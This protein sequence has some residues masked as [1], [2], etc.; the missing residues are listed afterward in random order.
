MQSTVEWDLQK[1]VGLLIF[2]AQKLDL[3]TK[4]I[5]VLLVGLVFLFI[6]YCYQV[7]RTDQSHIIMSVGGQTPEGVAFTNGYLVCQ[8]PDIS[9]FS[10][11]R[12]GLNR[13][14]YSSLQ[15]YAKRYSWA[16][17]GRIH[18][19]IR[20]QSRYLSD[21]LA[22]QKPKIFSLPDMPSAPYF[23]RDAQRHDVEILERNYLIV[24]SEFENLQ[25]DFS[26]GSVPK[27]WTVNATTSGGWY[28]YYLYNKGNCVPTNCRTCP[29]TYRI[30]NTLRTFING[31]V[32]GN[33]CFS[34]LLPGTFLSGDYGPT[35]ARLRCNLG[36]KIPQGC[37]LVVGGEPQCWSEGCCLLVDDSFLH[38]TSHNGSF[39]DGPRVI[40][41]V[42]LWHPNIAAAERQALDYIFAP[43]R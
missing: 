7:G 36:L 11:H 40:F 30:L 8:S 6:W 15:D 20:E 4:P 41:M 26:S 22:I 1:L 37:E 2:K 39:E 19:G 10:L 18:K 35:N 14:L 33:A 12:D 31:N 23:P 29:R 42:D 25:R 16:G 5:F 27:G 3:T 17:M 9:A 24:L 34:V 38:T 13:K 28:T 21:R 43:G 32:F